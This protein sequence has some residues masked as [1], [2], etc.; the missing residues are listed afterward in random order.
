[1]LRQSPLSLVSSFLQQL[2]QLLLLIATSSFKKILLLNQ[3]SVNS[4]HKIGIFLK[5]SFANEKNAVL[6]ILKKVEQVFKN[7]SC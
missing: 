7:E 4:F 5:Q 1:M 2:R 6:L 3:R